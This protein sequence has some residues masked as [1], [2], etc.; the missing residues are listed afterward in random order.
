MVCNSSFRNVPA[1][2]T[3]VIRAGLKFQKS[4]TV[5]KR[6]ILSYNKTNMSSLRSTT[7]ASNASEPIAI[8]QRQQER[9][10]KSLV[11]F[12][13]LPPCKWRGE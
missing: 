6:K 3:H 11:K 13:K 1:G 2:L 7:Q 5:L 9:G 10:A 8:P 4:I 12:T